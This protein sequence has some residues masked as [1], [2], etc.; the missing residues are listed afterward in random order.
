ML[1][2]NVSEN[3]GV[4]IQLSLLGLAIM[5]ILIG[6][7]LLATVFWGIRLINEVQEGG[8]GCHGEYPYLLQDSAISSQYYSQG[9]QII[10]RDSG[11]IIPTNEPDEDSLWVVRAPSET[12]SCISEEFLVRLY[13]EFN[14]DSDLPPA[15][16][17]SPNI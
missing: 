17:Q 15:G 10:H 7:T 4:T 3:G 14:N 13:Q 11:E 12:F 2:L 8:N 9:E 5:S 16:L 6:A 1:K